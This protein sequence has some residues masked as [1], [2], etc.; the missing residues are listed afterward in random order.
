MT[1]LSRS[2]KVGTSASQPRCAW[3]DICSRDAG[4]S[5]DATLSRVISIMD[6]SVSVT[7]VRCTGTSNSKATSPK[8]D[9]GFCLTF[10]STTTSCPFTIFVSV[11]CSFPDSNTKHT[12]TTAPCRTIS[13]PGP[14][15]RRVTTSPIFRLSSGLRFRAKKGIPFRSIDRAK[16]IMARRVSSSIAENSCSRLKTSTLQSSPFATTLATRGRSKKRASSPKV[17]P[18]YKSQISAPFWRTVTTPCSSMYSSFP[19]SPCWMI[20]SS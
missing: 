2:L 3:A 6:T 10:S 4:Q 13:T 17:V 14:W 7:S 8:Q 16:A 11:V 1:S 19:T 5:N 12:G 15:D 9:P 20:A 18:G